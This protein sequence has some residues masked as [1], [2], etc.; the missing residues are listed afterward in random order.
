MKCVVS[1]KIST[2]QLI[3]N[4]ATDLFMDI[5]FQ[6]TS[7]RMIADLAGITQPNLYYHFKTKEEIYIAV[8]EDL[9]AEVK[10][11]LVAIVAEDSRSLEEKLTDVLAYLR[12]KHPVNL[13]IM[14]H[15]INNEISPEKQFHL[16]KIWQGA[17]L[18]P[19]VE[20][21]N[22]YVKADSPLTATELAVHFY[23]TIAPYIQKESEHFRALTGGK[24]IHLFIYGILDRN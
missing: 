20:L 19:L 2:R 12:A 13:Y 11:K 15:D 16:Y 1:E 6:A 5:G 4:I 3:L 9:A 24:L 8:L 10:K 22:Q 18:Q 7:T 17:Y 14:R 21:F 23:G